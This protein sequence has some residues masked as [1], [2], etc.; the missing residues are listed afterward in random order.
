MWLRATETG[1]LEED[2][3]DL[4][5]NVDASEMEEEGWN[6]GAET[7]GEEDVPDIKTGVEAVEAGVHTKEGMGN[8][9]RGRRM[10]KEARKT[11]GMARKR[12]GEATAGGVAGLQEKQL[13][14]PGKGRE[15]LMKWR[16]TPGKRREWPRKRVEAREGIGDAEHARERLRKWRKWPGKR[17]ERPEKKRESPGKG[18]E[19]LSKQRER[20]GK[21]RKRPRKRRE[22][23]GKGLERPNKQRERLRKWRGRPGKGLERLS[24]QR[25]R[26]GKGWERLN[27]Q[28]EK[29]EKGRERLWE[30]QETWLQKEHEWP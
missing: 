11:N 20:P 12:M 8:M 9:T 24:K 1:Q 28:W 6:I 3:I 15:W 27:K 29:P 26:L 2:T 22:R 25:E 13:V 23:Q 18:L 4:E 5:V 17:R 10:G 16:E 30:Q 19:R 14:R 7:C 21:R